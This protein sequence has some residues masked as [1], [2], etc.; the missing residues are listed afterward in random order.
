MLEEFTSYCDT[1]T[2]IPDYQ[3]AYRKD[4]SC[5][6][7]IIKVVNDILWNFENQEVCAMCMI[8]L[9]AA[10]DTEDHQILLQVLQSIFGVSGSALA[11]FDSYLRPRF[12]KVNVETKYSTN[13]PV[14]CSVLQ[15]SLAGPNLYLAYASTLQEIVPEEVC[16][17]GFADNHSPKRSFKEDDR[18]A[19]HTTI[20]ILQNCLKDVKLW[21]DENR[22]QMN[23]G[24]TEFFI[25]G[26]KRQ[27]AKCTT[28]SID[29][30]NTEVST[31]NVVKYLSMW[32]DS[33]FTLKDHIVK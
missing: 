30:N 10:F 31:S 29:V 9:S 3:S 23:D 32:M 18:K 11:W 21:M 26:A 13:R 15:G 24:K 2:L 22:L 14:D 27:L 6:T 16:L 8:D 33:N 7:S 5:E 20:S 12:C 17:N 4:F 25:F 19:E 1:H 28:T